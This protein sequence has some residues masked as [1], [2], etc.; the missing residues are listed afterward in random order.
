MHCGLCPLALVTE[1]TKC[2]QERSRYSRQKPFTLCLQAAP[3]PDL[4]APCPVPPALCPQA[5]DSQRELTTTVTTDT[6]VFRKPFEEGGSRET[7]SQVCAH[8]RLSEP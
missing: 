4:A 7:A 8:S 6:I 2:Q 5:F 1:S 3:L